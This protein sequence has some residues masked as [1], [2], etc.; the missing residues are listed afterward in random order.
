MKLGFGFGVKRHVD[1]LSRRPLTAR[2]RLN[3]GTL[4]CK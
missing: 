3:A 2:V 4:D 1:A